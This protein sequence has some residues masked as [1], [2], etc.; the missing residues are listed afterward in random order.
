MVSANVRTTAFA[1]I[2]EMFWEENLPAE[3]ESFCMECIDNI[4]PQ[5]GK[6][7]ELVDIFKDHFSSG[8]PPKII[9]QMEDGFISEEDLKLM[10]Q[11]AMDTI[12]MVVAY[13][14]RH[15]VN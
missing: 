6:V 4:S 7:P 11:T 3:A 14:Q 5:S 15:S 12:D 1:D 10:Q 8:M 13:S 2:V 9:K